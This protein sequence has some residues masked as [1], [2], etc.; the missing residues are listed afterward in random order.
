[1]SL[2]QAQQDVRQFV[3]K[4][5]ADDSPPGDP[6][7]EPP[8]VWFSHQGKGGLMLWGNDAREYAD[9]LHSLYD[10]VERHGRF[11]LKAVENLMQVA[12]IEALDIE[13]THRE[14]TFT[15]RLDDA[16]AELGRALQAT[17]ASWQFY[18]RIEGLALTGLPLGVGK[19]QFFVADKDKGLPA[20][21]RTVHD[22]IDERPG[23]PEQKSGVKQYAAEVLN[24]H[25]EDQIIARVAIEAVDQEAADALAQHE[26]RLTLDVINFYGDLIH[27]AS[28][29]VLVCMRGEGLRVLDGLLGFQLGQQP[30]LTVGEIVTGPLDLLNWAAMDSEKAKKYGFKRIAY[31]L[32]KAQRSELDDR[33][34]SAFQWAG[35]A[36]VS[37][38]PQEAF[39]LYTIA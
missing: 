10:A 36:T 15:Q 28:N 23:A 14:K 29:R 27:P 1:M 25:F 6:L 11:S 3:R 39:L 22:H 38:R 19:V 32:T 9:C 34:L 7:Q 5:E 8:Q 35:R 37:T 24:R 4:L 12:I 30:T 20:L 18:Y 26:L 17:P 13:N 21:L 33:L 31:V 2:N 16:I